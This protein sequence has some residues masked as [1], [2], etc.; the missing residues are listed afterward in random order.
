MALTRRQVLAYNDT[1]SVYARPTPALSS[2]TK[3]MADPVYSGTAT[4]TG[5]KCMWQ[6]RPEANDYVAPIGRAEQDVMFTYDRFYFDIADAP[7]DGDVLELT[8]SG[9]PE[10]GRLFRVMGRGMPRATRGRR[11]ANNAMVYAKRIDSLTQT[12]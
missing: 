4:S 7:E 11:A 5:V 8:T 1:V 10:N 12:A 3:Q 6:S 2:G 9:H